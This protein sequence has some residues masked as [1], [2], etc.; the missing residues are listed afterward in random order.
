MLERGSGGGRLQGLA[1]EPAFQYRLHTLIGAGS[2]GHGTRRRRFQ[3]L[4]RIALPQSQN[5]QT[6]PVA[7]LRVGLTFQD[8]SEQLRRG[9]PHRL[10]PME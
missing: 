1:V 3:P 10:R 9:R 7:H 6:R 2:G 4:V 5:A 8:G